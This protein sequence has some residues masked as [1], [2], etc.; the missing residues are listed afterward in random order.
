MTPGDLGRRAAQSSTSPEPWPWW[1]W[2]LT[3]SSYVVLGFTLRSVVL[4]WIVGP[5]YPLV[6]MYLVA[7][8]FRWL[9]GRREPGALA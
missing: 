5:V 1:S 2:L 6:V 4:N 9:L 7:T 8:G 3:F